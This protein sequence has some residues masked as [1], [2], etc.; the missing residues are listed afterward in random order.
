MSAELII[1]S[2]KEV[3]VRRI[4]QWQTYAGL[5]EGYPTIELNARILAGFKQDAIGYFGLEEIYLIEPT[6]KKIEYEGRYPFGTPA[7]MPAITCVALLRHFSAVRDRKEGFF[8]P[9]D[10]LVS[11]QLCLSH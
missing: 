7:M 4:F 6:Q 9:G 3:T 8:L 5:L 2:N 1:D 11:G 10:H